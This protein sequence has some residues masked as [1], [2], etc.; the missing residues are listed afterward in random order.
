M[1]ATSVL[2]TLKRLGMRRRMA[3]DCGGNNGSR[4]LMDVGLEPLLR[5]AAR[6]APSTSSSAPLLL[7]CRCMG[8]LKEEVLRRRRPPQQ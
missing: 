7:G 5:A 3:M 2:L 1:R 8:D 4:A 6:L